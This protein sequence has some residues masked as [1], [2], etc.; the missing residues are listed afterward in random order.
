MVLRSSL[1]P[2]ITDGLLLRK[3]LIENLATEIPEPERV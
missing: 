3:I 1:L 2:I